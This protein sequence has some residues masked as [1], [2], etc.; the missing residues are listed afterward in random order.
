MTLCQ[1]LV[2]G[3]KIWF[4]GNLHLHYD[5]YI[6]FT[7]ILRLPAFSLATNMTY[8]NAAMKRQQGWASKFWPGLSLNVIKKTTWVKEFGAWWVAM[9]IS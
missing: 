2:H 4:F 1:H 8:N 3:L 5:S 6:Y 7:S 9:L